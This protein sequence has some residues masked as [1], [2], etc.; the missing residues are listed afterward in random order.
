MKFNLCMLMSWFQM[1]K[2]DENFQKPI[3][4]LIIVKNKKENKL[5][6]DLFYHHI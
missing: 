5:K 2:H 3:I 6:R 1:Y 4:R